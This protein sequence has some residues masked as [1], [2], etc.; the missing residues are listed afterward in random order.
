MLLSL[1]PSPS[2]APSLSLSEAK[3]REMIEAQKKTELQNLLDALAVG[4]EG[5]LELYLYLSLSLFSLLE[6]RE[7]TSKPM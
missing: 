3:R 6:S 1:P 2:L 4:A 5:G 7:I